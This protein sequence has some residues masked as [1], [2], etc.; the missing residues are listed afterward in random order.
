ML[1]Q[2]RGD[3]PAGFERQPLQSGG[4]VEADETGVVNMSRFLQYSN[5][6]LKMSLFKIV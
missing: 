6:S 1:R 5:C 4:K 3:G 2:R